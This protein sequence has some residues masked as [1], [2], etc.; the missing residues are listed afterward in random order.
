MAYGKMY[1]ALL[2]QN[3][4]IFHGLGR[5]RDLVRTYWNLV[6]E[7]SQSIQTANLGKL[8]HPL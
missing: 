6:Q 3:H 4:I 2:H 7:A 1:H 5:T 8:V